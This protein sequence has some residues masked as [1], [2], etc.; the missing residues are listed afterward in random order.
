MLESDS[1]RAQDYNRIITVKRNFL[2]IPD[3]M[4]LLFNNATLS[5]KHPPDNPGGFSYNEFAYL[6]I[7]IILCSDFSRIA[8]AC[9]YILPRRPRTVISPFFKRIS[10][11]S[12]SISVTSR[13]AFRHI[14]PAD[15]AGRR[16]VC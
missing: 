2:F 6:S 11:R 10:Y 9:R 8:R 3:V 5:Q 1:A 4:S 15:R 13:P 7:G 12:C 14:A 16:G